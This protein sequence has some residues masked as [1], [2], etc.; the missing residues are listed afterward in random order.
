MGLYIA[1]LSSL[2]SRKVEHIFF[3]N[4]NKELIDLDNKKEVVVNSNN[5]LA[6]LN[7]FKNIVEYASSKNINSYEILSQKIY[8]NCDYEDRIKITNFAKN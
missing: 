7:S 2:S 1:K 4:K 5:D 3:F 6:N 8:N